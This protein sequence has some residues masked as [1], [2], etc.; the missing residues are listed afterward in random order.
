MNRLPCRGSV[1]SVPKLLHTVS[2][3]GKLFVKSSIARM[4]LTGC[5]CRIYHGYCDCYSVRPSDRR[6]TLH[7]VRDSASNLLREER[8]EFFGIVRCE[9]SN[10]SPERYRQ[11]CRG[12][13]ESHTR[14]SVVAGT[15]VPRRSAL[16]Q[17]DISRKVALC[18]GLYGLYHVGVS[19]AVIKY[20]A[21]ASVLI[22]HRVTVECYNQLPMTK[23][24]EVCR[25][26]NRLCPLVM[27]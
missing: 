9:K 13:P 4:G 15:D 8:A 27:T 3:S 2:F 5:L 16:R 7:V 25:F 6:D 24:Q 23:R 21:A 12:H 19:T 22:G 20:L 26:V 14:T 17:M 10:A 18:T 1:S 11:S